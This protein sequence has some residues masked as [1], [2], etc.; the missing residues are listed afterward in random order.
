MF[1]PR[2]LLL[3]ACELFKGA[4]HTETSVARLDHVVD[5]S[6]ACGIVWVAKKVIVFLLLL[7]GCLCL[8]CRILDGLDLL[9]IEDLNRTFS[10]HHSYVCRR[11]CV[12]DVS[13]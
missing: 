7:L 4:D 10:T 8:L 9:R 12:V 2:V 6:V 1:L 3:L 5:V 13:A 11:P